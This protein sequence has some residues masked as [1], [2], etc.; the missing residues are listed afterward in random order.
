MAPSQQGNSPLVGCQGQ[1]YTTGRLRQYHLNGK[2]NGKLLD[3]Q[4]VCA[5]RGC[6]HTGLQFEPIFESHDADNLASHLSRHRVQ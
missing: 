4:R 1:P 5:M 2:R 6:S 3:D